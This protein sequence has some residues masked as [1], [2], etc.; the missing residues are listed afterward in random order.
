MYNLSDASQSW[1]AVAFCTL[2]V[3]LGSF[4]LLNVILAVIMNEFE[5]NSAED[6]E[7]IA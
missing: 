5:K 1:M 4:F 6:P 2:L 7:V 3:V